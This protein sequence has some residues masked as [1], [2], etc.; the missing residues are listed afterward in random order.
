MK[1]LWTCIVI[2]PRMHI[3]RAEKA[4]NRSYPLPI[5]VEIDTLYSRNLRYRLLVLRTLDQ[6]RSLL[7][8][9]HSELRGHEECILIF[10]FFSE[11]FPFWAQLRPLNSP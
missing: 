9:P 4:L 10:L 3:H 1:E 11:K 5:T 2:K 8:S 6:M 7:P